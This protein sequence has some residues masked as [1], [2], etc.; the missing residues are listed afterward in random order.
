MESKSFLILTKFLEKTKDATVQ[1]GIMSA[2][3]KLYGNKIKYEKLLLII[4]DRASYMKLA[5]RKLKDTELFANLHH[6]TCLVHAIH[7]LCD[8][9]R[10]EKISNLF[11]NRKFTWT[12]YIHFR[13]FNFNFELLYLFKISL[14]KIQ[15]LA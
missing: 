8:K 9:I 4:S 11:F 6:V 15:I 1:H 13:N 10:K 5:V 2:L 7:N 14:K 3:Q 12:A